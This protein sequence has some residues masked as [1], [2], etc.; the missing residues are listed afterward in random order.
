VDNEQI[1]LIKD[2]SDSVRKTQQDLHNLE[3]ILLTLLY[4]LPSSNL[5]EIQAAKEATRVV[6]MCA[7]KVLFF[8]RLITLEDEL[9]K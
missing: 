5:E 9:R 7:V 6:P 4:S 3:D 1:R 8:K 2:V